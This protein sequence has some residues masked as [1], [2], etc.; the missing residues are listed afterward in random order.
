MSAVTGFTPEDW[1]TDAL[2]AETDPNAFFVDKGGSTRTAKTICRSCIVRAEC[3]DYALRND[4]RFGVYGGLSARERA[5]LKRR[6]S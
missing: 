3:L 2:C 1:M 5:R 4:E 6:A